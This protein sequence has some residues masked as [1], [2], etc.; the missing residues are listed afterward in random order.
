MPIPASRLRTLVDTPI[1]NDG[2]FVLYWMTSARRTRFSFALDQAIEYASELQVPLVVL[3]ALRV[4]YPWASDR[5][6]R[7]VLDGMAANER[8]FSSSPVLYY[9]YLEPAVGAGKGLLAA[10]SAQACVTVTDDF[11]AFF[12]PRMLQAAAKQVR[13]HFVAVD[14][15]GLLPLST[16][17]K[18]YPTAYVFRR[19]MQKTLPFHMAMPKAE[20]FAGVSLPRLPALPTAIAERW[21]RAPA[22]LLAGQSTLLA[23]L[24]IDHSVGRVELKGGSE[25][26]ERYLKRFLANRIQRYA[27][28]RHL[29]DAEAD[30]QLSP[31]LHF[32]HLSVHEIVSRLFQEEGKPFAVE[33]GRATGKREGFWGV[34][35]PAEAFLDEV[36]TWRELGYHTGARDD[37]FGTY[38]SVPGWAR[39]SL[40]RHASD[41]RPHRYTLEELAAAQSSDDVWNAAQMQLRKEGRIHNAV[42]MIWGK[43]VLEW[44]S[45]AEETFAVLVELN[46]RYALD[47][48]N[49]NSYSGISWCLGKFDRPWGPE[50]PIFGVVRYMTT[51]SA[52][53][54][55]KLKPY[56]ERYRPGLF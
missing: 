17:E 41:P 23:E 38:A 54:K 16:S 4:D 9:P 19:F 20:P 1:R 47:G 43:K 50:R 7:F 12:L 11:P 46:N 14:G 29:P 40:A 6:H 22:E 56:I 13:S 18:L 15:N 5:F 34:S 35:G 55:Y 31:F 37:T 27:D 52:K 45:C 42:R 33:P 28:E 3:E 26:A 49:P 8:A 39:Q 10:L 24:P 53:R 30:S 32:G 25:T 21:P 48:R 44:T 36:I 51:D 2:A